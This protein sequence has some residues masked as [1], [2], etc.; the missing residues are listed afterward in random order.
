MTDPE[1]KLPLPK[2]GDSVWS[3]HPA[4]GGVLLQL[5]VD[6]FVMQR[7]YSALIPCADDEAMVSM[8]RYS[9]TDLVN[10][11]HA[12]YL[13]ERAKESREVDAAI[14]MLRKHFGL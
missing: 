2:N 7:S 11:A 13:K 10:Q 9:A 6:Y 5:T 8:T 1:T 14:R 12:E 3:L 4:E